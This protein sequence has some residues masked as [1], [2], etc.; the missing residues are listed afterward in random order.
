MPSCAK[1][2]GTG[3]AVYDVRCDQNTPRR[4]SLMNDLRQAVEHNHLRLYYQ[5]DLKE[6]ATMQPKRWCDGFIRSVV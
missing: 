1:C 5:V 2:N 4:L 3:Y 6:A